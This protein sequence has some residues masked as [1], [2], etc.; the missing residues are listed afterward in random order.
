[1]HPY[2]AAWW[3]PGH[4]IGWEHTFIHEVKDFVEAIVNDTP[5][6]PSFRDGLQTQSVLESVME[7]TARRTWTPVRNFL[8]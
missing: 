3:P 5:V 2:I 1:S 8:D 7:S 6:Q 4:I